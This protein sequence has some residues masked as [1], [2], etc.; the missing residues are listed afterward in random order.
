MDVIEA[1]KKQFG[2][3][4]ILISG[5]SGTDKTTIA[6]RLSEELKIKYDN[7]GKFYDEKKIKEIDIDGIKL[8]NVFLEDV[9]N[10]EKF[11]DYIENNKNGIIITGLGFPM[12]KIKLRPLIHIHLKLPRDEI[13]KRQKEFDKNLDEESNKK[14]LN[15]LVYPFFEEITKKGNIN[16]FINIKDM[17]EEKV[18]DEVFNVL[19]KIIQDR[20]YKD[21][22]DVVWNEEKKVYEK[23]N[24]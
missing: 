11:N 19:M 20:L 3:F 18:M 10:W 12:E 4:V 5:L 6:K 21:V 1:Y 17:N 24:L 16:K 14:V 23:K 13:I 15:K 22:K 8:M 7:L 9:Y 2:N